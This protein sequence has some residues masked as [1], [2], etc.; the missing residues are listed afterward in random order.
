ML[1]ATLPKGEARVSW[2]EASAIL[3]LGVRLIGVA[4]VKSCPVRHLEGM[5]R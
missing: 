2:Q 4:T 1:L 5:R 3:R